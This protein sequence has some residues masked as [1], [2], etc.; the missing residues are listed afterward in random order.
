[1]N[2]ALE[3]LIGKVTSTKEEETLKTVEKQDVETRKQLIKGLSEGTHNLDEGPIDTHTGNEIKLFQKKPEWISP[4]RIR[5]DGKV[6]TISPYEL[7][8]FSYNKNTCTV[9]WENVH[10]DP[11]EKLALPIIRHEIGKMV[12]IPHRFFTPWPEFK[13]NPNKRQLTFVEMDYETMKTFKIN[14]FK[15]KNRIS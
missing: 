1:M 2:S 4:T 7:S 9:I 15:E 6:Y 10:P 3:N 11:R 14:D 13:G 12:M 5:V 8:Y